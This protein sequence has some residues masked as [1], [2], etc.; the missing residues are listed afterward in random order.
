VSRRFK[1]AIGVIVL[2]FVGLL[3]IWPAFL[4]PPP[5]YAS[6]YGWRYPKVT[7]CG[8]ATL[9]DAGPGAADDR[10]VVDYGWLPLDAEIEKTLQLCVLPREWMAV[11]LEVDLPGEERPDMAVKRVK[12]HTLRGLELGIAVT[13]RN[14]RTV[15]SH[16]G[17]L[18]GWTWS[19]GYPPLSAFVY[20]I[21]SM[22]A[23]TGRQ[24]Y[25]LH[26]SVLPGASVTGTRGRLLVKGGGWKAASP[27]FDRAVQRP[28][29]LRATSWP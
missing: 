28:Q 11:G 5:V 20:A 15:V 29:D 17:A 14:G 25:V 26:V 19:Y 1:I 23:P 8:D 13:D 6:V 12:E 24:T 16:K 7:A 21:D 2:A 22:F 3:A 4:M 10:Y 27:P 9:T 18:G